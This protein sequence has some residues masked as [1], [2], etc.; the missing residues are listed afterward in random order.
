MRINSARS[1]NIAGDKSSSDAERRVRRKHYKN[2]YNGIKPCLSAVVIVA[3]HFTNN[4]AE[5]Q[6]KVFPSEIF[7]ARLHLKMNYETSQRDHHQGQI[8]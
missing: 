2:I 7:E 6:Q 8:S 5:I 1:L 4:A 3:T